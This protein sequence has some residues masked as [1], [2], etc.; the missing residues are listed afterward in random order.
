MRQHGVRRMPATTEHWGDAPGCGPPLSSHLIQRGHVVVQ[1]GVQCQLRPAGQDQGGGSSSS[2]S[3][4]GLCS[5]R[6]CLAGRQRCWIQVTAQQHSTP[7]EQ[8][9]TSTCAAL[10]SPPAPQALQVVEAGGVVGGMEVC[11]RLAHLQER[12]R[13]VQPSLAG[14]PSRG[15]T[16]AQGL[17]A[18]WGCAAGAAAPPQ[19]GARAAAGSPLAEAAV[20]LH[21]CL[22]PAPPH[23]EPL[24]SSCPPRAPA[25]AAP[26]AAT[27]QPNPTPN[28][29]L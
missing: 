7:A 22:L 3:H 25:P 16:A 4:A 20:T 21:W 5:T 24:R 1:V 8:G 12:V 28:K 6:G 2:G 26:A 29:C 17:F 23:P 11:Q 9:G 27:C 19:R 10:G 13:A 15:G 18:P 14:R